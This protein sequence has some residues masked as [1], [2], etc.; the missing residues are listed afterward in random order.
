M[1]TNN[2]IAVIE[3]RALDIPSLYQLFLKNNLIRTLADNVFSGVPNL[4]N[5]FLE[6]NGLT[7]IGQSLYHLKKLD[8]LALA[9][10]PI[11]DID[12]SAL[13]KMPEL[14][15]LTL[16]DTGL[17]L[18]DHVATTPAAV[19]SSVTRLELTANEITNSDVLKQLENLGFVNLFYLNLHKN[20][21]SDIEGIAEIKKMFP[22]IQ[23][24]GFSDN[25][26]TCKWVKDA[27]EVLSAQHVEADRLLEI[28]DEYNVERISCVKNV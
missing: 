18:R 5:L 26:L 3:D 16:K 23:T 28:P 15:Q 11:E 10:N 8:Y 6:G 19:N 4:V 2:K 9:H 12:L 14:L 13:A 20:R 25:K 7:H 22:K 1:L 24:F 27:L 17:Q 21:L